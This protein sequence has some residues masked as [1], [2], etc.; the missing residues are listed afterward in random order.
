MPTTEKNKLEAT[1]YHE[2][3]HAVMNWRLQ[4]PIKLVTTVPVELAN[5][6]NGSG[7]IATAWLKWLE[8]RARLSVKLLWPLIAAV[9][10]RLV[11]SSTLTG[12]EVD[13]IYLKRIQK[14]I[15]AQV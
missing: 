7:E 15:P 1:A 13:K 9:A 6:V 5:R 3:G 4:L 2:A 10:E 11:Q 12:S 8:L 14:Q